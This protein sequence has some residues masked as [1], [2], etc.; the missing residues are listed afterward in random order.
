MPLAR[1]SSTSRIALPTAIRR[2]L[3]IHPGDTL[4][5][6]QQGDLIAIRKVT[7]RFVDALDTCASPVWRD[8]A[9][10]LSRDKDQWD[11]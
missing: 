1:L 6:T 7:G 4:E 8:Y 5:I 11:R 2:N 10:E 3:D 9:G